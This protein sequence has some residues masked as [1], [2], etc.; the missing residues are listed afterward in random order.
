MHSMSW[1]SGL[2]NLGWSQERF[3]S[4]TSFVQGREELQDLEER[5]LLL[6]DAVNRDVA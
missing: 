2:M 1:S 6:D 4:S 5:T 3:S